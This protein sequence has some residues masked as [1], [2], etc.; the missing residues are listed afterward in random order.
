MLKIEFFDDLH[1]LNRMLEC[2]TTLKRIWLV[3]PDDFVN[4]PIAAI[5][6]SY[7]TV[8]PKNGHWPQLIEL[9]VRNRSVGTKN[10]I[11]L[12]IMNIPSLRHLRFGDINLLDRWWEGILEYLQMSKCHVHS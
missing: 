9:K 8:F 5:N 1:A 3:L 4:E 12:R 11:K 6:F 2:M 7:T 10:L